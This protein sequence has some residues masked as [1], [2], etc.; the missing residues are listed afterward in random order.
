MTLAKR[1]AAL[2]GK[3]TV[4]LGPPIIMHLLVFPSDEPGKKGEVS[5]IL[6]QRAGGRWHHF[7]REPGEDNTAFHARAEARVV[8]LE[9]GAA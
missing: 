3:A 7:T 1:L 8:A 9:A 6:V 2:E 4:R 5:A